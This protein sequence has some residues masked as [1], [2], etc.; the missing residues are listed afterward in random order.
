MYLATAADLRRADMRDLHHGRDARG[1]HVLPVKIEMF[2][3]T[4]VC[5]K[6]GDHG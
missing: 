5:R 2:D 6:G 1:S 3:W 4:V